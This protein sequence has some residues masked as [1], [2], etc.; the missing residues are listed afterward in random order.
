VQDYYQLPQPPLTV[1]NGRATSPVAAIARHDQALTVGRLWDPVKQAQLLDAA[2]ARLAIP[3]HAAGADTGPH[4][5]HVALQHLHP[6]GELD[7]SGIGRALAAQPV[8]V[9]AATFEPFGLAVLEAAQAGCALV[10]SDIATF[11]ELWYGAAAFVPEQTPEAYARAVERLIGDDA[12]RT[13]L[14]TAARQRAARY[15]PAAN[16]AAMSGIYRMLLAAPQKTRRA[17]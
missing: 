6:L 12:E 7:A 16:A 4:G 5:E 9:S 10:L 1:H 3:F 11:R 17:A 2:A 8:F 13:R 15:T 14:G